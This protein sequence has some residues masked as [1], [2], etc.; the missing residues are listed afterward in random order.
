[1]LDDPIKYA[2]LAA[3]AIALLIAAF[4][5]LKSRRIAN[6][7]NATIALGAPLFWFAS[8]MALWPDVAM[9]VGLA[10]ATF[11][12]LSILFAIKAMGGGD[13]K[14]LTALALWIQPMI[15]LKLLVMMALLGGVLTLLFGAWH[16]MRRQRDKLAIPYGVAIALAGLWAIGSFYIPAA[17]AASV[18]G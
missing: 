12:V 16:I 18:A 2:L 9:Q 15:F 5:D 1:M 14:L 11:A 7:L 17:A 10:L 6:W 8:D 13:V 4:T 3:L